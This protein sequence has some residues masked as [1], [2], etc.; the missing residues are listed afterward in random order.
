[1]IVAYTC[2]WVFC[3]A[4]QHKQNFLQGHNKAAISASIYKSMSVTRL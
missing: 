4:N 3:K 2:M 1:M